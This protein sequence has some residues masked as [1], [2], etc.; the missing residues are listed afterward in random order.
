MQEEAAALSLS[1]AACG[2]APAVVRD[3]RAETPAL[4][5]FDFLRSKLLHSLRWRQ[6]LPACGAAESDPAST[7]A[8]YGELFRALADD[9]AQELRDEAFV[10]AY[11][12]E[13]QARAERSA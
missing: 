8:A 9:L 3:A 2:R 1:V 4:D 10:E 11:L 7:R 5:A 13:R 12:A 6:R